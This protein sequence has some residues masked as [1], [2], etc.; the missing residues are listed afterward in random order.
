MIHY[1]VALSLM[2]SLMLFAQEAPAFG[3]PTELSLTEQIEKGEREREVLR[4]L[5][6]ESQYFAQFKAGKSGDEIEALIY[7]VGNFL[8][9]GTGRFSSLESPVQKQGR[10]LASASNPDGDG[11][12]S[13]RAYI[14]NR[15]LLNTLYLQRTRQRFTIDP[16]K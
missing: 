16:T 8:T 3:A 11:V 6:L 14:Q 15:N 7:S 1:L 2:I 12:S 5:I 10:S 4:S 9:Y 13:L